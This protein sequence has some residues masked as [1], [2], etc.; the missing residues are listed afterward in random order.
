MTYEQ[1]P[2]SAAFPAMSEAEYAALIDSVTAIGV[3]NPI[4]IYEGMVL[5]GWNRYRATQELGYDCPSVELG[6]VDPRDFV[7]AQNKAR[8]H[9]TQAQLAMAVTA[10][11]SWKP[12][13]NPEFVQSGTQCRVEKSTAEL[14]EI[15][16]VG[17]RTIRQ[18]KAVQTNATP[19]IQDA[20]KRGEVGLPK[21]AEIAKLPLAEQAAALKAPMVRRVHGKPKRGPKA[22][23]IR[24]ELKAAGYKHDAE[25]AKSQ[26]ERL[27]LQV[28]EL[29]AQL[30]EA[31]ADMASMSTILDAGDQLAAALHEA[32]EARDLARGLQERINSMMTQIAELK[33]EAARWKKKAEAV[34]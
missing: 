27:E 4:T 15:S 16:G 31:R 23:F 10:V 13:G 6:D 9:V 34:A 14:A 17:E 12:A 20:V 26:I 19:E 2:L 8:R 32:K 18:A 3:Q 28:I 24:A 21:A 11:H 29:T 1:H 22:D 33:R 7:I 5:D 30:S 25:A